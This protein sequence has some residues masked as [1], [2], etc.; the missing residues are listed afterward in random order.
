M[1]LIFRRFTFICIF[2]A[3]SSL[4]VAAEC[5]NSEYVNSLSYE[6]RWA[7]DNPKGSA[8]YDAVQKVRVLGNDPQFDCSASIRKQW[9]REVDN[10]TQQGCKL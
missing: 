2:I 7:N 3:S 9:N 8:C 6:L 4:V 1:L 10:A 5:D